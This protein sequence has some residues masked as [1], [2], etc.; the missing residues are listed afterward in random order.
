MRKYNM[1]NESFG[2]DRCQRGNRSLPFFD[3]PCLY[4]P[5][6]PCNWGSSSCQLDYVIF[7]ISAPDGNDNNLELSPQAL[8]GRSIRLDTDNETIILQPGRLY[9]LSYQISATINQSLSVI[10]VIDSVS[11]LCSSV[12][13]SSAGSSVQTLSGTLLLPVVET[14]ST[15]QLQVQSSSEAPQ[16]LHGCVSLVALADL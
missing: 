10:P 9:Q 12:T 11:D 7:G 15:L 13:V 4:Y 16:Q 1:S 8:D 3:I 14:A 5:Q 6:Y 2:C